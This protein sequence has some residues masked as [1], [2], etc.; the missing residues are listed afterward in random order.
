[1]GID[2]LSLSY[3]TWDH[4]NINVPQRPRLFNI[5]RPLS[6]ERPEEITLFVQRIG[7]T[8]KRVM[9]GVRHLIKESNE[10]SSLSPPA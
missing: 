1:M 7:K 10:Q 4:S 3:I 8:S 2:D 6:A 5:Q 9:S